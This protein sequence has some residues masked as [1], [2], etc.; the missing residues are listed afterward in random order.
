MKD[1]RELTCL[2]ELFEDMALSIHIAPLQCICC[3]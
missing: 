1:E 2:K 3:V